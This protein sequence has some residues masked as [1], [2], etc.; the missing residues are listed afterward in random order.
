M[1]KILLCSI[2]L[3]GLSVTAYCGQRIELID[4]NVIHANVISFMNGIYTLDAGSLG[5]IKIDASKIKTITMVKQNSIP[6]S[7][8]Q[9]LPDASSTQSETARLKDKIA[10][11]PEMMGLVAEMARDPQFQ[12]LVQ[13]PAIAEALR[14]QN[15][16]ALMSNPKFM[17]ILNDP[18]IQEIQNKVMEDD[19]HETNLKGTP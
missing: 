16:N 1:K 17:A 15:M 4:G 7:N 5:Q 9:N 8:T 14:T 13:D 6:E 3:L 11:N 12:E 10:S 18:K 19:R 2:F